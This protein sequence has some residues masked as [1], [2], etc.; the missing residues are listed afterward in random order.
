MYWKKVR[1]LD[2]AFIVRSWYFCHKMPLHE[3]NNTNDIK[4]PLSLLSYCNPEANF[5][6]FLTGTRKYLVGTFSTAEGTVRCP[7]AW[8]M[9]IKVH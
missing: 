2:E 4:G 9:L 1:S 3:I 7:E 8:L 6:S 5:K